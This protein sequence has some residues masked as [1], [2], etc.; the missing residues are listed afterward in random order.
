MI[1]KKLFSLQHV[2]E[3]NCLKRTTLFKKLSASPKNG[4]PPDKK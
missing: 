2:M 3:K 1:I 4:N